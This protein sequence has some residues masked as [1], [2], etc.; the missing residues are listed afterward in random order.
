MK[1]PLKAAVWWAGCLLAGLGVIWLATAAVNCTQQKPVTPSPVLVAP[2]GPVYFAGPAHPPGVDLPG[3][4]HVKRRHKRVGTVI[5]Y[6]NGG[7]SGG[8]GSTGVPLNW[9]YTSDG[10]PLVTNP[11]GISNSNSNNGPTMNTIIAALRASTPCG[12]RIVLGPGTFDDQTGLVD[13]YTGTGCKITIE[14]QGRHGTFWRS[15]GALVTAGD[16]ASLQKTRGFAFKHMTFTSSAARSPGTRQ[17]VIF[18]CCT[19]PVVDTTLQDIQIEDVGFDKYYDGLVLLD[20]PGTLVAGGG[21]ATNA[22]GVMGW[23]TKDLHFTG[24]APNGHGIVL[25]S[26]G[27][28]LGR[29]ENTIDCDG[30]GVGQSLPANQ[31]SEATMLISATGD[32]RSVLTESCYQQNGI[33]IQPGRGLPVGPTYS[34]STMWMDKTILGQITGQAILIDGTAGGQ[35]AGNSFTNGYVDGTDGT[36][37][38]FTAQGTAIKGLSISDLKTLGCSVGLYLN[39]VTVGSTY[40]T[41]H[42]IGFGVR[43]YQ[44]SG[45]TSNFTLLADFSNLF[46]TVTLGGQIDSGVN[47]FTVI[48]SGGANTG[49]ALVDNSGSVDKTVFAH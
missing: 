24:G 43:G 33:L 16:Q 18:G 5:I 17:V 2:H 32:F 27:S 3:P 39:G 31:R 21:G 8:G 36:L 11:P 10:R 26:F 29:M 1:T 30:R 46:G 42:V 44:I 6:P 25:A 15:T 20:A 35:I 23:T 9:L 40:A 13:T 22:Q 4:V 48:Q 45:G 19:I 47:H 38:C 28:E 7:G 41:L 34:V 37:P 14:G 12:G 49:T